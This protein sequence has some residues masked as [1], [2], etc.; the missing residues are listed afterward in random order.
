M[1]FEKEG[2]ERKRRRLGNEKG[3]VVVTMP[4]LF[5]ASSTSSLSLSLYLTTKIEID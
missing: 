2:K 4:V 5:V 1:S 3:E